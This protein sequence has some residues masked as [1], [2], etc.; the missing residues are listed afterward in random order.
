MRIQVHV[1]LP[2]FLS[3]LSSKVLHDSHSLVG[4]AYTA[5]R[6][7]LAPRHLFTVERR[8][9]SDD[10]LEILRA[11]D[12]AHCS[13][14]TNVGAVMVAPLSGLLLDLRRHLRLGPPHVDT[15][16]HVHNF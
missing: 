6:S 4:G 14:L 2:L 12:L 9:N 5:D 8:S 16:I 3:H 11:L 13:S 7:E 1:F 15:H 10:D